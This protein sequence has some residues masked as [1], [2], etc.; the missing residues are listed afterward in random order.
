MYD[1]MMNASIRH[2]RILELLRATGKVQVAA[3]ASEIGTSEV[4]V[5]RDLEH[6]AE[7]GVLRRVH[8]GAVSIM[9]LGEGLPF[10]MREIDGLEI[11]D[12]LAAAVAALVNDGEA[13]ALD[14]GT[15]CVRVAKAFVGR[16]L[17][18]MPFS[19]QATMELFGQNSINLISPGGAVQ[20]DEGAIMGPLA[21]ASVRSLRFDTAIISPCGAMAP[22]GVTAYDIQDASLK[23]TILSA[24][25]RAVLV[26]D[27]SKFSRSAMATVCPLSSFDVVV[28]DSSAPEA[29]VDQL[30]AEGVEVVVV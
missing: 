7:A 28:T 19:L 27:G 21:E 5:R 25:R 17:T 13:I 2:E 30:R 15:S 23:R 26:A 6:L 4:T 16:R 29:V 20:P 14:S 9:M 10:A 1:S 12:R 24:A 8:G 3:L 22:D 11:K 18:V